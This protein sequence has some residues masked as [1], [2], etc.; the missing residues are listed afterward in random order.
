MREFV[1]SDLDRI[2]LNEFSCDALKYRDV[3]LSDVFKKYSLD[4][5]GKVWCI[6]AFREHK[7]K[8]YWA[9]MMFDKSIP[10][11]YARKIR[12]F[13]NK[14]MADL[15][16]ELV[17]TWSIDCDFINRWHRFLGLKKQ[18]HIFYDGKEVNRWS[19]SWE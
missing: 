5:N 16:P 10:F 18:E 11:I 2:D 14:L 7:P 4:V 15:K 17:E 8:N 9:F 13:M 3:F 6:I 19:L 12:A 1:E